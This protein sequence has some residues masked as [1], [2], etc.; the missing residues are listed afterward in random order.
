[1]ARTTPMSNMTYGCSSDT[2][3]HGVGDCAPL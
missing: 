1:M 2:G 3:M